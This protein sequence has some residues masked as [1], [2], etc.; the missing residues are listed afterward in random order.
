MRPFAEMNG[1]WNAYSAFNQNGS[2]RDAAHSTAAFRKA[3]ARV[4][5]ILH[6][7]PGVN[8]RLARARAAA[9]PGHAAAPIRTSA[10]SGTRRA[11]ATP[12]CRATP[13]RPTTPATATS[14][15]SATTSTTFAARRRGL[16]QRRS[17]RR[18][19]ASRSASRSGGCGISTIPL[20]SRR[21]GRSCAPTRGRRSPTTTP[22]RPGLDLRPRH[23]AALA[24]RLPAADQPA[25]LIVSVVLNCCAPRETSERVPARALRIAQV[26]RARQDQRD[27]AGPD[28]VA[29]HSA[30]SRDRDGERRD[31]PPPPPPTACRRR[32][33]RS[34]QPSPASVPAPVGERR[35][36]RRPGGRTATRFARPA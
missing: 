32:A 36:R 24:R 4:Y 20:S 16:R 15:S 2:P 6:G 13:R 29:H 31:R 1:Y 8:A 25:G 7:G 35:A 21:W 9:G 10:S 27:R 26:R 18:I 3:F 11:T 28:H 17:T 5:L 34:P 14:T 19:Q 30:G 22:A 33:P 23:E 12:I